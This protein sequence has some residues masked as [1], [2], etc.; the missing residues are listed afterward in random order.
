MMDSERR[1][2]FVQLDVEAL[3]DEG[4]RGRVELAG[5]S[6]QSYTG[7]ARGDASPT[8]KLECAARASV[9]ALRQALHNNLLKFKDLKVVEAFRGEAVLVSVSLGQGEKTQDLVGFCYAPADS[10]KAAALAVLNGTN[11]LMDLL[12][13]R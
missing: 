9:D 3:G 6:Q 10:S 13:N 1:L 4:W 8:G 2:R 12:D 11:R 5:P 7:T